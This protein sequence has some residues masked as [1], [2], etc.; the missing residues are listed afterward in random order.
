VP[1]RRR[2]IR[3][4]RA[5]PLGQPLPLLT[6]PEALGSIRWHT[7]SRPARWIQAAGRR[8]ADPRLV[9]AGRRT[10]EGLL[11]GLRLEP[12]RRRLAGGRRDRDP[13]R[14]AGRR[15]GIRPEFHTFVASRAA[16]DELPA[17]GLRRFD[18]GYA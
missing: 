17:D 6:L 16:W 10:G 9:A 4:D 2:P 13:A 7:G 18:E 1:V 11:L 3:G 14:R 12:L 15:S 5:V 8:R